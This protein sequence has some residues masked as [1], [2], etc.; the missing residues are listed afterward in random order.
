MARFFGTLFSYASFEI[1]FW[2]VSY[3]DVTLTSDWAGFGIGEKISRID[4]CMETG[5]YEFFD[6]NETSIKS[7]E[8]M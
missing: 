7:G 3:Y 5:K 1:T 2:A 8:M 6:S 4:I